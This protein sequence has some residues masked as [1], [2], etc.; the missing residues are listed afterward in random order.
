M[1]IYLFGNPILK[2]DSLPLKLLLK[3]KKRFPQIKFVVKDPTENWTENEKEIVIID[4]VMGINKVTVFNSLL[5]LEK[6][7]PRISPHDYDVYLD[8]A[9]LFK[10]KK[11]KSIKIIGISPKETLTNTKL[12]FSTINS[13]LY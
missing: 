4:T 10:L 9:L 2:Q 6:D 13:L 12:L 5:D 3:L 11:I 8:L 1:T 7:N